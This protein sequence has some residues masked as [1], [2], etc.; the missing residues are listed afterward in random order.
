MARRSKVGLVLAGGGA[1]GAYEIGALSVLLPALEERGERPTVVVGASV[2][3][4]NAV[5]LAGTAGIGAGDAMKGARELWESIELHQVIRPLVGPQAVISGLRYVGESLN[6]PGI[7][8]F[9]LLDP[10]PLADMLD[11]SISWDDVHRN[12]A[13]GKLDAG[14]VVAT[15][16]ASSRSVVFMDGAPVPAFDR[17]RGIDYVRTRLRTDHVLASAAIPVVFPAVQLSEP[18]EASGWYFD[19]GTRLNTPIKPAI[20]LEVD[21]VVVIG[22]SSVADGPPR[23]TARRP[24]YAD[25]ALQLLHATLVDPLVHDIQ[26]L[27]KRNKL[28]AQVRNDRP[29]HTTSVPYRRIPYI[30]VAPEPENDFGAI[31]SEIYKKHYRLP[32]RG[33]RSLDLTVLGRLVDGDEPMHGE[34][35]SYLFFAPEFVREL[36]ALGREDA[37]RYLDRG[38]DPRRLEPPQQS[39]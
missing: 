39:A 1:R 5:Y 3:A 38:D 19:G 24:D 26:S 29:N 18:P 9:N 11:R 10:A 13:S 14:G 35:L 30:F 21:R 8:L 28:L 16:A 20:K 33:L 34:L 22:L 25:G 37:R 36:I 2:G 7:R 32:R 27:S 15:S 23:A 17:S 12:A 31:A 4:I 6:V